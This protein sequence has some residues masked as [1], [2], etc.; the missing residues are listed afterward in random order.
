MKFGDVKT[1]ANVIAVLQ[2]LKISNNFNTE[3][4][5]AL[6]RY[7]S[8]EVDRWTWLHVPS[9][10]HWFLLLQLVTNYIAGIFSK[11]FV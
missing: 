10:T 2:N 3:N 7:E 1:M 4:F 9:G 8:T 11:P 6:K 5:D